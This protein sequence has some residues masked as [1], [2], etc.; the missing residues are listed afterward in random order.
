[1]TK[2]ADGKMGNKG[3]LALTKP[4]GYSVNQTKLNKH[5]L[6]QTDKLDIKEKTSVIGTKRSNGRVVIELSNGE[7]IKAAVLID[8]SGTLREPS[9]MLGRKWNV[10]TMYT[11]YGELLKGKHYRDFGCEVD[12]KPV[13]FTAWGPEVPGS[14]ISIL[15]N[16]VAGEDVVE[17]G[18]YTHGLVSKTNRF[19]MGEPP[20][21][22]DIKQYCNGT[23]A[24]YMQDTRKR[25]RA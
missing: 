6:E 5:L 25:I 18:T 8:A 2:Y 3:S 24:L 20:L 1:V 21:G 23:P 10:D 9:R 17:F 7:V 11:C 4:A 13:W 14:E 12:G 15:W 19:P 16:Y 22:M